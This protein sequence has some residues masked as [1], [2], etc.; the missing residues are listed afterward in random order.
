MESAKSP[1]DRAIAAF[2]S[3]EQLANHTKIPAKRVYKWRAPKAKGGSDGRIPADQQGVILAAARKLN[4]PLG[5]ED[6]ID[7]RPAHVRVA[8]DVQ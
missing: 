2:G 7:M 1:T 5:A 4:L 8:E 6:L 3:V